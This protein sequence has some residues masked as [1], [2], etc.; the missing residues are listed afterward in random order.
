[1]LDAL[2]RL[3]SPEYLVVAEPGPLGGLGGLYLVLGLLFALGL[4][5]TLWLLVGAPPAKRTEGLRVAAWIE[6]WIC[7]AGLGTVDGRFLGWPGWSD[8][9]WP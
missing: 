9:I 7:L 1:M 8:R 5:A 6:F 3:L 4:A 2:K